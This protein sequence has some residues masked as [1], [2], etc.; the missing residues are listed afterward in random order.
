MFGI[1]PQEYARRR[2][3][4][5]ARIGA[6]GVAVIVATPERTRSRDT[7]YPY[8]ASSDLL[9]LTGFE[10][11]QTVLVVAPGHAGGD[12][13][14]F[15]RARDPLMEQWDGRRAGPEGAVAR[16]GADQAFTLAE[17]DA[18]LPKL[19]TGRASLWYTLGEDVAFDTRMNGWLN[20]LRY[21]RNKPGAAPRALCDVRDVLHPMRR[22]KSAE[23]IQVMRRAAQITSE[24]HE[25]AMRAC[26]PGM[27]EYE[28]QALI[29]YHFRRHGAAF[30]SYTSIVGAGENATILHYI[31]NS[32]R[33]GEQDVVLIDAGCELGYYAADITRSFPAGGAF[34]PAQRD[35]YQGVLDVQERA[36][37]LVKPGLPYQEL[38]TFC[39]RELTVVL[40][41]LGLLR[42]DVDALVEQEAYKKYYP[43]SSGHWLGVDVHDVGDYFEAEQRPT[44]LEPGMV[45]TIEPG[46]YIPSN[47]ESAPEALRGVG[48]RIEDDLLV[49]ADGHENLTA[50]CPKQID[51]IESIM[52]AGVALP[53]LP[54]ATR[55]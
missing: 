19:L 1:S 25:L 43:H 40:R 9:Y 3:D 38:H 29:E 34:T 16:Y 33:I 24:A 49:T 23:E 28:L 48:I 17:L 20:R 47:D 22:V 55:G 39:A 45:L 13:T 10:E 4:L 42:G 31:E 8:R 6:D 50:S 21:Q 12:V 53:Q 30:P 18:E 46:L 52:G 27:Y 51:H 37:A 41:E 7:T 44:P 5:M 26:R 11:P 2:A 15:V 36:L 14:L 35:L 32:A 54:G